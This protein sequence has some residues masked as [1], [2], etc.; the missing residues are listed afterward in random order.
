MLGAP[1]VP[2]RQ[3]KVQFAHLSRLPEM[4]QQIKELH[5]QVETLLAAAEP[6]ESEP[7]GGSQA[8]A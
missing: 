7:R 2:L 8:A 5:R 3:Q 4:R 6:H 1:A